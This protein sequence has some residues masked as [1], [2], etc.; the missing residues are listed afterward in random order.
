MVSESVKEIKKLFKKINFLCLVYYKKEKKRK[1]ILNIIKISLK[2]ICFKII[3]FL[4]YE[5]K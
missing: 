4:Y 5:Q 2:F 3:Q 1:R